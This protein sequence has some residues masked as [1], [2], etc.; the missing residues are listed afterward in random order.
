M[1]SQLKLLIT[2]FLQ[3]FNE[4]EDTT[5]Q[6]QL[7]NTEENEIIEEVNEPVNKEGEVI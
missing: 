2:I 7:P 4:V 5:S 3:F 1:P 6:E